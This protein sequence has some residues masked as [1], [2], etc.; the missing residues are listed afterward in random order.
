M[1][2]R[3][4][5]DEQIALAKKLRKEGFTKNKLA[6]YF[7]V[8]STTI[9]QNVY[10]TREEWNKSRKVYFLKRKINYVHKPKYRD[11]GLLVHLIGKMKQEEYTS[12]EVAIMFDIPL[13][14]VNYIYAHF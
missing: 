3:V 12:N 5:T 8:G 10:T 2:R 11:I 13:Q 6:E 7:N 9:W 14:E 4:L 1:D